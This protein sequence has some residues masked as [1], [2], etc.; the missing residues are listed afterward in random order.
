ML[1]IYGIYF[2]TEIKIYYTLLAHFFKFP[3]NTLPVWLN[4]LTNSLNPS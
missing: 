1:I 3:L 2:V 4:P